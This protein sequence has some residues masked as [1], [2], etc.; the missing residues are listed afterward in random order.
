MRENIAHIYDSATEH[1]ICSSIYSLPK[2]KLMKV[3][4]IGQE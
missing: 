3:L 2:V 1:F 4:K